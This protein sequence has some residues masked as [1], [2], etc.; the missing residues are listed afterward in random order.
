[1]KGLLKPETKRISDLLKS[2]AEAELVLPRFQ[3]EFVWN[4]NQVVELLNSIYEQIPIGIFLLW[5]SD[6]L[7][8]AFRFIGDVTP[9]G[10]TPRRHSK[11]VLDGQQR[12]TSLLFA[13]RPEGI[14]LPEEVTKQYDIYF[15]INDE[16]FYPKY[17]KKQECFSAE[18]LGSNDKFMR[19]YA[20]KVGS[21]KSPINKTILEKLALFRDYEVPLLIF[22]EKVDLDIVS[23][24]FQYLNAKG[25]PLTLINLIAA[26]TYSLSV[27]DLYERV[28]TT[29]K[30]LE[31]AH[32]TSEDFNGENLIRS[33]AIYNGIN[34]QTKTILESLKTEHL[35]K[36]YQKAEKAYLDALIFINDDLEMPIKLLPYPPLLVPLTA[37]FMK[38][39][40]ED[41]SP[42]QVNYIKQWFW[43]SNFNS[44]YGSEAASTGVADFKILLGEKNMKNVIGLDRPL[45]DA[46]TLID[47]PSGS[48]IGKAVLG[49]LQSFNPLDLYSNIDLKIKGVQKRKKPIKNIDKHHIFPKDYLKTKLRS[50]SRFLID[51]VCNLAWVSQ[52]TN[53]RVA[54]TPPSRYFKKLQEINKDFNSS[55]S[56]QF[57]PTGSTSP[58]WSNNYKKFLRIRADF[59][60][61]EARKKCGF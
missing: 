20:E 31:D 49:L 26:K 39:A 37:F 13:L 6:Q 30:A 57:I 7:G 44:R 56:Q 25:T 36:D 59:I 1:M 28:E 51:S 53:L 34:N 8:E 38:K 27:F 29:Q 21:K 16:K 35:A 60:Y 46:E 24:T 40:R 48:A 19:F 47:S 55:A 45:F 17:Q 3:R 32:F 52:K 61:K 43:R 5:D 15:S 4:K 18:I 22:D 11:Y 33:I 9:Q 10:L 42:S 12:L 2:V 23:K 54:N 50:N 58:I 14:K 41:L